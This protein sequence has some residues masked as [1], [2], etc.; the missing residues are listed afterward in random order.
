[1]TA[2][3][4]RKLDLIARAFS[5]PCKCLTLKLHGCSHLSDLE[6]EGSGSKGEVLR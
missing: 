1:M 4:E 6:V 2:P 5:V 3:A